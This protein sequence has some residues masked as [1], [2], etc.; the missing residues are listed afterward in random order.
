MAEI[1]KLT[2]EGSTIWPA[3]TTSAIIDP[4]TGADLEKILE[5]WNLSI[6]WPSDPKTN[7]TDAIAFLATKIAASR[8]KPGVRVEFLNEAGENETW[9]YVG[10][11]LKSFSDISA[12][13]Q[14]GG[15]LI[16]NILETSAPV[17]VE[18]KANKEIIPVGEPSVVKYSWSASQAG[19]DI[20]SLCTFS[21][22]GD[23]QASGTTEKDF[24]IIPSKYEIIG[25]TITATYLG[26]E[27][28]VTVNVLAT[29][30]TYYGV[31]T[32]AADL[33]VDE[34]VVTGVS[35]KV[36]NPG[37]NLTVENINLTAQRFLVAFPSS[38]GELKSI[39]DGN[40][41]EYLTSG[42]FKYTSAVVIDSARFNVYYLETPVTGTGFK[43]I[44]S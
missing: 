1:H 42:S 20:T 38:M 9:E 33:Y 12:W 30:Y 43:F 35:M 40:G 18:F 36:L 6:L 11:T 4:G 31:I 27:T 39:K 44:F 26:K 22:D 5:T 17:V 21:I 10:G 37:L 34:D 8:Q 41:L 25:K 13:V 29:Q 14:V 28:K 32:G 16:S 24:T 15:K 2:K 19:V 3:T 23:T 7:I